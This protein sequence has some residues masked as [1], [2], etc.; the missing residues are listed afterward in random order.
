MRCNFLLGVFFL[1]E[2]KNFSIL[3]RKVVDTILLVLRDL[4]DFSV[5]SVREFVCERFWEELREINEWENWRIFSLGLFKKWFLR[6]RR[7]DGDGPQG[8]GFDDS[9]ASLN[10]YLGVRALLE[11][12]LPRST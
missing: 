1:V 3:R 12:L 11:D 2:K 6:A 5:G 10:I 8:I 7:I 9:F 4:D